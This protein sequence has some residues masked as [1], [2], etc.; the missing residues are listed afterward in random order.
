MA[1]NA[2]WHFFVVGVAVLFLPML[3]LL[4]FVFIIFYCCFRAHV[5]ILV[6][7]LA[8]FAFMRMVL[9]T[10]TVCLSHIHIGRIDSF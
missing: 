1:A 7:L 8:W 6:L 10:M 4:Y 9:Y 3:L 5:A 2:V